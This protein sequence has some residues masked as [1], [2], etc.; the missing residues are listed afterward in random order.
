MRGRPTKET[1]LPTAQEI[2]AS[3]VKLVTVPG[4][5]L[6][7]KQVVDNPD[8]TPHDLTKVVSTDPAMTAR[9]LRLVNSAFWGLGGKIES[10]SRAVSLLGM[11]HVHDVVLATSVALAFR[12]IKPARMDVPRFWRLSVFRALAANAL[13]RRCDL[14]DLERLFVEGLL[15]DIGHMVLYQ[16]VPELAARALEHVR[17]QPDELPRA[18]RELIGCDYAE[19]GAE[20]C[21][22]WNLPACFHTVI[23]KQNDPA[24]AGDRALEAA[25]V[26]IASQLAAREMRTGDA[27]RNVRI[28][29][30]AW[31]FAGL[32]ESCLAE[33]LQETRDGLSALIA[34]F[35]FGP[36][37]LGSGANSPAVT[38]HPAP[39][40][41]HA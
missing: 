33:V 7:V 10:V 28:P 22:A 38:T 34:L 14:A 37:A 17:D 13:A 39:S 3:S 12:G 29:A 21:T 27:A 31:Q 9:V 24:A 4:I 8:T 15:A 16:R 1:N 20:L 35:D 25:L 18:E 11:L 23:G 41:A 32:D 26:L 2:V 5:Y 19:V 6:R 36:S 40:V 30:S